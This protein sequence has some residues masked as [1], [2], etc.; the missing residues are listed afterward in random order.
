[1]LA[2][3][4]TQVGQHTTPA[5]LE[6]L[7]P[8]IDLYRQHVET[9]ANPFFEGRAP[10]TRGNRLAADYI[11]WNFRTIGLTPAFPE[12]SKAADGTEIITPHATWRQVFE[13]PPSRRPGDSVKVKEERL[14]Y[15]VNGRDM[16]LAPGR[17]F[18]VLGSSGSGSVE[19]TPVF[20]GYGIEE[21]RGS[22]TSFP[23][24]LDLTGKIAIVLRFE[25]LNAD[26]KSR[27]AERGWSPWASLD[28]K[29]KNAAKRGAAGIILVNTPGAADERAGSLAGL[30]VHGGR[31]LEIPV[32]MATP[33]AIDSLFA[34][35]TGGDTTLLKLREA[36]DAGTSTA[37]LSNAK[38]TLNVSME[39]VPLMTDNVGAILKG[40]GPLADQYIVIGAHYDHVGYGYFGSGDPNGQGTIHPGADDNASGTS[41]VLLLAKR[42]KAAY[43]DLPD[44]A[45]ARSILFLTFSCEESGLIGSQ[46][47]CSH[48]IA[49]MERHYLMLNMDMIGRMSEKPIDVQDAGTGE[50]L[51]EWAQP[52]IANSGLQITYKDSTIGRSDHVSFNQ[53]GVPALMFF[54]G[55]HEQYHRPTDVASLINVEGAARICD[56]VGRI[57]LD[58]AQRTQPMPYLSDSPK[59]GAE[60]PAAA[61]SGEETGSGPANA[62]VHFGARPASYDHDT[63]GIEFETVTAGEPA[64][65]AGVKVGDV[66]V[67]WGGTDV[68]DVYDWMPLLRKTKPGDTVEIVVKRD[69]KDIT[70]K[71]AF[72]KADP[73]A[74]K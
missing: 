72:P 43:A 54:S 18:S 17:D 28:E 36:A 12:T 27:W 69:G 62:P 48:P 35:A 42:L 7:K 66:M 47:Y 6:Q 10:G 53:A 37:E 34:A 21:G 45:N 22:Y 29:L 41:G 40:K 25:P 64:D 56:L 31:P 59:T 39:R 8:D 16:A 74:G 44:D 38:L 1:M 4:P 65:K 68:K 49:P 67:K 51:H 23:E 19:A 15:A 5:T 9:L 13:A 63:G 73:N 11:E 52:Y 14:T 50:G 24:K 55:F 20:V 71:A 60:Q 32:V 30:E 46:W 70:L 3:G 2:A 57:A 58:A 33:H 26:G 61:K